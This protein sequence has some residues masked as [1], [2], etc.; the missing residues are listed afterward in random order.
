MN[1]IRAY[2]KIQNANSA[3]TGKMAGY[4]QIVIHMPDLRF[5]FPCVKRIIIKYYIKWPKN[6]REVPNSDC[7]IIY[8]ILLALFPYAGTKHNCV[9]LLYM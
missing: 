9:I 6:E 8:V 4:F 5:F 2:C 3:E 1:Y 7:H